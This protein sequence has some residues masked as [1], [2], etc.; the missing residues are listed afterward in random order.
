MSTSHLRPFIM[1]N[2]YKVA[3]TNTTPGDAMASVQLPRAGTIV[4]VS[5]AGKC[6]IETDAIATIQVAVNRA[7]GQFGAS[8]SSPCNVLGE[9]AIVSNLTTSGFTNAHANAVFPC[10]Y[11]VNPKDAIYIHATGSGSAGFSCDCLISVDEG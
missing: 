10:K 8:V 2:T 7:A 6:T 1:I 11:P 3:Y 4:Q 5:M 9:I